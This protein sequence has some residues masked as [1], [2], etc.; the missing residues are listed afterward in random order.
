[1]S[2]STHSTEVVNLRKRI[3]DA[4]GKVFVDEGYQNL[5]MRRV[6][7]EAGCS[8]MAMYRHFANKEAL[9]Q[10]LCTQLYR[11]FAARLIRESGAVRDPWERFRR[12]I[13]AII[14]FAIEYPDHYALVFLV[15]HADATVAAER[16]RLGQEFLAEVYYPTIEA[17]LPPETPKAV[18]ETRLRQM[19]CCLHGTAALLIAHPRAYGLSKQK[20]IADAEGT[21]ALLF[22]R[23]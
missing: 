15:R 10:H 7:Q 2:R 5:S 14:R 21:L 16:E 6:A 12:M 8:Q 20:A 22:G 11:G 13:A 18:I 19:V 9:T 3:I 17:L 1:M 4:A 23:A